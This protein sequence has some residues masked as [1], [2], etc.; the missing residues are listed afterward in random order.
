MKQL[1]SLLG[2]FGFSR[3]AERLHKFQAYMDGVL[4]W[5]QKVNLT[6]ITTED[7]FVQKHFIDSLAC[8]KSSEF[9]KAAHIV[10]VGTGAGFPG[11]PL[12]IL[13]P[14]KQFV[15]VDSL[16][17]RL[18]VIQEL[19]DQIQIRNIKTI[20][21]RAEDL[22]QDKNHR[23]NYDLC[24]SR[25][26]AALAVLSE[27]C[28]PLVKVG[29][30]FIAYK[31]TE[32]QQELEDSYGAIAL[33]GGRLDRNVAAKIPEQDPAHQLIYIEKKRTTPSKYP[34]KAGTPSKSPLS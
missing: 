3:E 33:L 17:K 26:V 31:G 9:Q 13:Y 16:A 14:K 20:H 18:K 23:E 7:A 28:L 12:A 22:G 8:L 4:R 10:D 2:A 11:V 15:L 19:C 25:A 21:S 5:N 29:G 27:Y 30:Y 6:A 24:L 32:I 34:R 1:E